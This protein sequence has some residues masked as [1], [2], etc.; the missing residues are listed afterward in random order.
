MGFLPAV[1]GRCTFGGDRD[2]VRRD[3]DDTVGPGVRIVPH[4]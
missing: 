4:A 1:V 2:P 3:G